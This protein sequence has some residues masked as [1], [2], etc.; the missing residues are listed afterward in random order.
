MNND[1]AHSPVSFDAFFGSLLQQ[2]AEIKASIDA[3]SS[4]PLLENDLGIELMRAYSA[5]D[6]AHFLGTERVQSVYEIPGAELPAVRRIGSN[7]G[8]LGI[9]ILCYMHGLK[10]VDMKSAIEG[11]R[12]KLMDE[13]PRVVPMPNKSNQ[14]V[15]RV[16]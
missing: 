16:L 3:H 14:N 6:V 7:K 13:R 15:H 1:A 11:Y 2:M 12:K 4:A 8:Y 10:P 9:N 5:K